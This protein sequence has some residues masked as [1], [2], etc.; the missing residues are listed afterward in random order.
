M[1]DVRACPC[2]GPVGKEAAAHP[3]RLLRLT[4]TVFPLPRALVNFTDAVSP[5]FSP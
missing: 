5:G 4:W 2:R 3:V 1:S